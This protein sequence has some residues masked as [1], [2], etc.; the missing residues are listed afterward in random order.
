MRKRYLVLIIVI[1]ITITILYLLTL[2]VSSPFISST[3][4]E[5]QGTQN[6]SSF[7]FPFIF[8]WQSSNKPSSTGSASGGSGS[9]G[10]G[11]GGSSNQTTNYTQK[12][13]YTLNI[14][15]SPSGFSV[16]PFYYKNN[17]LQN[18]TYITPSSLSI[19]SNTEV[20]L[21]ETTNYRG[22]IWKLDDGSCVFSICYGYNNGCN[23]IMNGPHN[24]TLLQQS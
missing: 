24:I 4:P 17:I 8:P 1:V 12:V 19:E 15:S 10:G 22:F 18:D 23:I 16:I 2:P 14:D 7:K 21:V 11:G 20:C 9:E 3:E 13:N 5:G 6:K